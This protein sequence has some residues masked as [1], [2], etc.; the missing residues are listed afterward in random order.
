[1]KSVTRK[2][3]TFIIILSKNKLEM[4]QLRDVLRYVC[5]RRARACVC[6]QQITNYQNLILRA[7]LYSCAP[8]SHDII[9]TSILIFN[10]K[11]L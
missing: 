7:C 4:T 8:G 3:K 5:A 11:C 2:N 1:M 6:V 10:D 9:N